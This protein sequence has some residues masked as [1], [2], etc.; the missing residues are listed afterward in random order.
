MPRYSFG[1]DERYPDWG[2]DED[3]TAFSV[4]VELSEED[5]ADF[6]R[7]A[8]EYDSWQIRLQLAVEAAQAEEW[9]QHGRDYKS[10]KLTDDMIRAWYPITATCTQSERW[11]RE[12]SANDALAKI[13][14]LAESLPADNT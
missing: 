14:K 6:R 1:P 10:G 13:K 2:L 7:V 4:A 3:P 11:E 8:A 12:R 5:V 9:R